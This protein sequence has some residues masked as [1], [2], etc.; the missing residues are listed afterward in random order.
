MNCCY[1]HI[2]MDS[3]QPHRPGCWGTAAAKFL[4]AAGASFIPLKD[5]EEAVGAATVPG[6]T[7][8]FCHVGSWEATTTKGRLAC[9]TCGAIALEGHGVK[10]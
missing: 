4:K 7:C 5:E 2:D 3:G 6:Q 8:P 10:R 9:S 1:C